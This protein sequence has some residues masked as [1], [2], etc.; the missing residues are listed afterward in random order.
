M[1]YLE[2]QY[3]APPRTS[4]SVTESVKNTIAVLC[5]AIASPVISQQAN[6]SLV[7]SFNSSVD[8]MAQYS[9]GNLLSMFELKPRVSGQP[10]EIS[11]LE[12]EKKVTI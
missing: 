7:E 4:S 11:T 6:S 3:I 10:T 1:R 8:N 5:A 9:Q 2:D 12:M